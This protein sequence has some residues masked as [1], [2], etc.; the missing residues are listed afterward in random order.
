MFELG[1]AMSTVVRCV[2]VHA[3]RQYPSTQTVRPGTSRVTGLAV[4]LGCQ[5]E[6]VIER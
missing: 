6:P 2:P 4:R 1:V 5:K 3:P